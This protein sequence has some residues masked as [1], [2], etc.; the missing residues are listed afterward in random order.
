MVINPHLLSLVLGALIV[1][2]L[3]WHKTKGMWARDRIMVAIFIIT[4]LLHMLFARIDGS[5][6]YEAYLVTLGLFAVVVPIRE[7]LPIAESQAIPGGQLAKYLLPFFLTLLFLVPLETRA[8]KALRTIPQATTNIYHQQYQMG[9]FLR[10]FYQG[11]GVAAND[12]GAINYLADIRCVDLFGLGDVEP[13]RLVME[14]KYDRQQIFNFVKRNDVKIAV[15]YE[16]WYQRFGG[17]PRRW[18][19]VGTWRISDNLVCAED[20]VA[21][22]A[23]DP[24]EAANLNKNLR[25][26]SHRLPEDV[27]QYVVKPGE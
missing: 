18:Q 24:G 1:F 27:L 14:G 10:E 19:K 21:F 3:R 8:R 20:E 17:L 2:A 11:Q 5:F 12:I 26:F 7:Y 16:R 25:A 15:I 9:L 13:I 23:V 4:T 6:R 22:Y